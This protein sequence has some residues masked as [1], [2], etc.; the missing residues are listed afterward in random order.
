[1]SQK[2]VDQIFGPPHIRATLEMYRD[3]YYSAERALIAL[4]KKLRAAD[5]T[6]PDEYD[7][8]AWHTIETQE[9]DQP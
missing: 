2:N 9:G 4:R 6:L 7:G 3:A 5:P 1:M 8:P